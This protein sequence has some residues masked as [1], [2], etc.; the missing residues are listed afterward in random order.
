MP[1]T[2][3]SRLNEHGRQLDEHLSVLLILFFGDK[4]SH[5]SA[6]NDLSPQLRVVERVK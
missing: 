2:G 1:Y 6:R 4:Q 5:M 3:N